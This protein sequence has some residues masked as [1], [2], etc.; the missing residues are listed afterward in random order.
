MEVFASFLIDSPHSIPPERQVVRMSSA[1]GIATYF[2]TP[3]VATCANCTANALEIV[4]KLAKTRV[5]I[6]A[7]GNVQQPSSSSAAHDQR[8]EGSDDDLS[9][10]MTETL[11]SELHRAINSGNFDVAIAAGAF[12]VVNKTHH[13]E[14]RNPGVRTSESADSGEDVELSS[15]W[16]FRE[17]RGAEACTLEPN[18]QSP[19]RPSSPSSFKQKSHSSVS[20]HRSGDNEETKKTR[21]RMGVQSIEC[22]EEAPNNNSKGL[23]SCTSCPDVPP[24]AEVLAQ[25]FPPSPRLGP[26]VPDWQA[27]VDREKNGG[28][29]RPHWSEWMGSYKAPREGHFEA[30]DVGETVVV[31]NEEKRRGAKSI[32]D[33]R[34]RA[35]SPASSCTLDG[36]EP[37]QDKRKKKNKSKKNKSNKKRKKKKAQESSAVEQDTEIERSQ[38][39][40]CPPPPQDIPQVDNNQDTG[41]IHP[42]DDMDRDSAAEVLVHLKNHTKEQSEEEED[43]PTQSEILRLNEEHDTDVA[44]PPKSP[45]SEEQV[46]DNSVLS[47]TTASRS[48]EEKDAAIPVRV[49]PLEEHK[50]ADK[51]IRS[52]SLKSFEEQNSGLQL[53]GCSLRSTPEQAAASLA[54]PGPP[55]TEEKAGTETDILEN[56]SGV[57]KRRDSIEILSSREAVGKPRWFD[58]DSDSEMTDVVKAD[59]K[60]LINTPTKPFVTT[61]P[62]K[63]GGQEP[64]ESESDTRRKWFDSVVWDREFP[65]LRGESST[66]SPKASIVPESVSSTTDPSRT[67]SPDSVGRPTGEIGGEF[68]VTVTQVDKPERTRWPYVTNDFA[69]HFPR[70]AKLLADL[71][72]ERSIR[73]NTF[74]FYILMA[75]DQIEYEDNVGM[76]QNDLLDHGSEQESEQGPGHEFEQR[77][78]EHSSPHEAIYS[79]DDEDSFDEQQEFRSSPSHEAVWSS[80]EHVLEPESAKSS[81]EHSDIYPPHETVQE[82]SE[83][84]LDNEQSSSVYHGPADEVE[85]VSPLQTIDETSIRGDDNIRKPII[86][87]PAGSC[88]PEEPIDGPLRDESEITQTPDEY[89]VELLIKREVAMQLE[90][91]LQGQ[92]KLQSQMSANENNQNEVLKRLTASEKIQLEL[93]EELKA[94]RN[95]KN[96]LLEANNASRE[97]QAELLRKAEASDKTQKTLFR[98]T[99]KCRTMQQKLLKRGTAD[100]ESRAK[101]F[102]IA[103]DFNQKVAAWMA[104]SGT[105]AEQLS[106]SGGSENTQQREAKASSQ[107]S[108]SVHFQEGNSVDSSIL[109]VKDEDD[110]AQGELQK[111]G[112]ALINGG[113]GRA[114]EKQPQETVGE[115]VSKEEQGGTG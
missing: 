38:E 44:V 77:P 78:V 58:F 21:L 103:S 4:K 85:T 113:N 30:L 101:L 84:A 66:R 8:D 64:D 27:L 74:D 69:N 106:K 86:R 15:R 18:S 40:V 97:V 2:S 39:D 100:E 26:I 63:A 87:L 67:S 92:D 68:V 61:Q 48:E 73:D 115:A 24:Y 104:D 31:P 20:P 1:C 35:P 65:P 114:D 6:D 93:L 14:D 12:I 108:S 91:V 111:V 10:N 43:L 81:I 22:C 19:S 107:A 79:A 5:I 11:T 54:P 29:G 51:I 47:T 80:E 34:A 72:V 75:A 55:Q 60:A 23:V 56:P 102:G 88:Y 94:T 112:R 98:M 25:H 42:P 41:V 9:K 82:A 76:A 3:S 96:E 33:D 105:P 70:I 13:G 50:T 110:H 99:D 62:R 45:V 7:H 90:S 89:D 16:L 57:D 95:A 49:A 71:E 28:K 36:E 109:G 32:D 53:G 37:Q 59:L 83:A 17:E 52:G 46:K